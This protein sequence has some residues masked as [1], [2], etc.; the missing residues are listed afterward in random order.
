MSLYLDNYLESED[1]Q[2]ETVAQICH[3]S[4]IYGDGIMSVFWIRTWDP[5]LSFPLL[6][7]IGAVPW[8]SIHMLYKYYRNMEV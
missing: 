4:R 7:N 6:P 2:A 3:D 1:R 8:T 5:R